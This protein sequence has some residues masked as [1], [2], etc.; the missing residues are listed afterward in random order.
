MRAGTNHYDLWMIKG[1]EQR[2]ELRAAHAV[3]RV[4]GILRLGMGEVQPAFAGQQ[5]LAADGGHGVVDIDPQ[6]VPAD[7]LR[8]HQ[9]GGAA[10][11]DGDRSRGQVVGCH[12]RV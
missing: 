2:F 4:E 11:D 5:E 12:Q 1:I 8:R 7:G 3:A 10:A 9:P 6:A